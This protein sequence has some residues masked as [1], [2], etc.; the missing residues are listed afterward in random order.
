[1]LSLGRVIALCLTGITYFVTLE[2]QANTQ[3]EGETDSLQEKSLVGEQEQSLKAQ[4][5][6]ADGEKKLNYIDSLRGYGNQGFS[7]SLTNV[8]Y[9]QHEKQTLNRLTVNVLNDQSL[10]EYISP[11][12]QMGRK[13]LKQGSNM[14]MHIPGTRNILRI[15]PAQRLIGQASN[16]DVTGTT[17]S[18]DYDVVAITQT[19]LQSV[20]VFK[21]EL[22]AKRTDSAYQRIVFYIN[23]ES[24]LP[25]SSEFYSRT[26][27]LLKR[28]EYR[29]FKKFGEQLKIHK[30][31]LT[32]PINKGNFTWMKFEHYRKHEINPVIF[33]KDNLLR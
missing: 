14:W 32:D 27:R 5:S 26:K 25:I 11:K 1:M 2:T 21:L 10:V 16:G 8:S 20:N 13:I 15:T 3:L 28:A 12:R 9:R 23:A 24:E 31:L 7:F 22:A 19:D 29:E 18:S 6:I 17:F 33:H 30:M 4:L